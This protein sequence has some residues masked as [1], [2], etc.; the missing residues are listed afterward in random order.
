MARSKGTVG[1]KL[2]KLPDGYRY[3]VE[4][5][6]PRGK[7]RLGGTQVARGEKAAVKATIEAHVEKVFTEKVRF[8][9]GVKA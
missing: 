3:W 8:P 6:G 9:G 5:R 2:Q 7:Q 1:L 4:Y